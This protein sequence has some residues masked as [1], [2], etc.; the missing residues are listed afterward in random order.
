M[1]RRILGLSAIDA[2]R[3]NILQMR[4]NPPTF[5]HQGFEPRSELNPKADG[6]LQLR[7]VL[8]A[9]VDQIKNLGLEIQALHE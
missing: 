1:N 6:D 2:A 3:S 9:V 4:G 8:L 5:E 7:P